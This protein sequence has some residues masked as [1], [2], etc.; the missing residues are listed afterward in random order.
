MRSK[1]I[2]PGMTATALLLISIAAHARNVPDADGKGSMYG[3]DAPAF[4]VKGRYG[5]TYTRE[6]LAG[7]VLIL[8]FGTSW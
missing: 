4:D 3:K 7:N 2:F 5:E 6:R 8:Q 1:H